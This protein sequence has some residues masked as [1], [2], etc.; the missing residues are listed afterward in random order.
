MPQPWRSDAEPKRSV[1]VVSPNRGVHPARRR[2]SSTSRP[3]RVAR[4]RTITRSTTG[5]GTTNGN[6]TLSASSLSP[7][8]PSR[9]FFLCRVREGRSRW[10][11]TD[12]PTSE[13]GVRCRGPRHLS[14]AARHRW[15]GAVGVDGL[16]GSKRSNTAQQTTGAAKATATFFFCQCFFLRGSSASLTPVIKGSFTQ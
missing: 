1:G 11:A 16:G 5:M 2:D 10:A 13:N 3:A 14:A 7:S 9:E 6:A 15:I 4:A 12:R 8:P